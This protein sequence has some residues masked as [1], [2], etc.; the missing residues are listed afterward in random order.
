MVSVSGVPC[1]PIDKLCPVP[2]TPIQSKGGRGGTAPTGTPLSPDIPPVPGEPSSPTEL[3]A[4]PPAPPLPVVSEEPP[5]PVL[6]C[7]LSLEDVQATNASAPNVSVRRCEKPS[8][9]R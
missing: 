8:R 3:P 7:A 9:R 4:P 5:S 2:T 6:F 1:A